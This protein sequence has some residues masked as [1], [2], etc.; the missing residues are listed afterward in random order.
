MKPLRELF[1]PCFGH[2][3]VSRHLR[4]A[5]GSLMLTSTVMESISRCSYALHVARQ[6]SC[7]A[8]WIIR[9]TPMLC[10][11]CCLQLSPIVPGQSAGCSVSAQ[12]LGIC[13]P[14]VCAFGLLPQSAP[15]GSCLSFAST[16]SQ[17]LHITPAQGPSRH[18]WLS[19]W[20]LRKWPPSWAL[21][22]QLHAYMGG[23]ARLPAGVLPKWPAAASFLVFAPRRRGRKGRLAAE[24]APLPP[25]YGGGGASAP[26]TEQRA[27]L[28]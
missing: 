14:G 21:T 22:M 16:Y 19:C 8:G 15:S 23:A 13:M 7:W 20:A 24:V 27:V 9:K 12:E 18:L 2:L 3:R 6:A 25:H 4:R 5:Q 28:R 26:W 1:K 17:E 10:Q 11:Y